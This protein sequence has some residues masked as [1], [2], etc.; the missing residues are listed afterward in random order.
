MRNCSVA[1]PHFG[2]R[3]VA[4]TK[5][6]HEQ[7]TPKGRELFI[8]CS[9]CRSFGG[10]EMREQG[11]KVQVISKSILQEQ[12]RRVNKYVLFDSLFGVCRLPATL[13]VKRFVL[14]L[15]YVIGTLV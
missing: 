6:K 4:M 11:L 3:Q 10:F 9:L 7:F 2:H 1:F 5:E 13:P 12:K 14:F 8:A 15:F